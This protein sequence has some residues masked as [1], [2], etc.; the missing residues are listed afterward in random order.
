MVR[1]PLFIVAVILSGCIAEEYFNKQ[2]T[3]PIAVISREDGSGTRKAFSQLFGLE[4]R[5]KNGAVDDITAETAAVTNSA[6]VMAVLVSGDPNAIGYLSLGT[7]C[8]L[9]K[10]VSIDNISP[11]TENIKNGSYRLCRPFIAVTDGEPSDAVK[12]FLSF[13]TSP[14]G[15]LIAEQSGLV[16]VNLNDYNSASP[17]GNITIS[18]SSSAMLFAQKLKEAYQKTNTDVKISIQQTDSSSGIAA[19]SDNVCDIG[20]VSRHPTEAELRKEWRL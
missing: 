14:Y 12:D 9:V 13:S 11:T 2:N 19:V 20:L 1:I 4:Q 10:T 7:P 6:A 3:D 18:G 8:D 16:G 5:D 17:K 15:S